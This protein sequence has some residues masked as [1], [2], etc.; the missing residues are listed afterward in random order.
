ME[1]GRRGERRA[2]RR[3][4]CAFRSGASS[5][6]AIADWVNLTGAGERLSYQWWLTHEG[7]FE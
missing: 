4:Y 1:T 3:L 7:K 5:E 6:T 2:A